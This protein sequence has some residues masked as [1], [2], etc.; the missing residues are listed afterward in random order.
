M[1]ASFILNKTMFLGALPLNYRANKETF[2][3][4][5]A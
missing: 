5:Y 3:E 1:L 2:Q 4:L